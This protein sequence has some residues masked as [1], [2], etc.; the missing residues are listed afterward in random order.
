LIIGGVRV[1]SGDEY[2]NTSGIRCDRDGLILQWG[3]IAA[4]S[5]EPAQT[6][7][8]E[9]PEVSIYHEQPRAADEEYPERCTM[10]EETYGGMAMSK[11][12]RKQRKKKA[13][14]DPE[15]FPRCP[16]TMNSPVPQMRSTLS[17]VQWQKRHTEAWR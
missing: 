6:R 16:Y 13:R 8:G 5:L 14:Q 11:R 7:P 1:R 15:R 9:V 12:D 3:S 4:T 2:S 10:A 17:G